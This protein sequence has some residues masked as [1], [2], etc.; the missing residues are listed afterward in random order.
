MVL[1]RIFNFG[2]AFI[3]V[4]LLFSC[5]TNK[6]KFL[7]TKDITLLK[8][9]FSEKVTY[10]NFVKDTIGQIKNNG[11]EVKFIEVSKFTDS[12]SISYLNKQ[13]K[14]VHHF[15]KI[16]NDAAAIYKST[17]YIVLKPERKLGGH[18]LNKLLSHMEYHLIQTEKS[19]DFMGNYITNTNCVAN[20][21][22]FKGCTES[23]LTL[24]SNVQKKYDFT[25]ADTSYSVKLVD[26]L[27]QNYSFSKFEKLW[28]QDFSNFESIY[29]KTLKQ[30]KMDYD[31]SLLPCSS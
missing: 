9:N 28:S 31:A 4:V 7:L 29:K 6:D 11:S 21:Y 14:A 24:N 23:K 30:V 26:F 12:L 2:V 20:I 25:T 3:V 22:N 10:E 16:N 1:Q 15:Y 17:T 27:L 8:Q 19:A 5:N 18:Q 13:N